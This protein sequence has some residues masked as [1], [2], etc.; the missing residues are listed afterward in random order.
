MKKYEN[1]QNFYDILK[2][3]Q[4]FIQ[5]ITKFR[6]NLEMFSMIL[7]KCYENLVDLEKC[8]KMSLLSLS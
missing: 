7:I 2:I 6:E 5:D 1:K 3:L 4:I 8:R